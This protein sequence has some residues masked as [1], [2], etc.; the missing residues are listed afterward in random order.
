MAEALTTMQPADNPGRGNLYQIG[1][2]KVFVDFAHNPHAMQALADL[3]A[4][5]PA[6]RRLLAFAHAGDRTDELLRESAQGGWALRPD[7]VI[8]SELAQYARGRAHG[9]VFG[10]LR[11][12][13]VR[14]GC[15]PADI[16][17]VDTETEA[18]DHALEW[19]R[20]GDL[21]ILLILSEAAAV[22]ARLTE[23]SDPT[24]PRFP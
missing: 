4:A 21:L 7:R 5:M 22:Q 18:L 19:A 9:E 20:P 17:H 3:S 15:R 24:P 6:R 12:E 10:V 13:L 2:I 23:L 11:D 16:I 14:C 8:I 1:E